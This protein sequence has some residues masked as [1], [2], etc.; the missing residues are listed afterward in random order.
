MK[1][2]DFGMG[3]PYPVRIHSVSSNV[4][5]QVASNHHLLSMQ[6]EHRDFVSAIFD[7]G[8]KAASPASVMA[9]MSPGAKMSFEGLNLERIKSKL[10]KFRN[11]KECHKEEF[12]AMY[13][14]T[15]SKFNHE[16]FP[17]GGREQKSK[18]ADRLRSLPPI[19]SLSSA[20]VAAFLSYTVMVNTEVNENSLYNFDGTGEL[21]IPELTEAEMK[22]PIGMAFK[23]FLRL[24]LCLE[25]DLK[26]SRSSSAGHQSGTKNDD[27]LLTQNSLSYSASI[28][29]SMKDTSSEPMHQN[30][31]NDSYGYS[32][33][34]LLPKN[35]SMDATM[36]SDPMHR[37][38]EINNYGY[39]HSSSLPNNSMGQQHIHDAYFGF[40]N[41]S[42]LP[43]YKGMEPIMPSAPLYHHP[44]MS[45]APIY[46][47]RGNSS[48]LTNNGGIEMNMPSTSMDKRR[49]SKIG[50]S[51]SLSSSEHDYEGYRNILRNNSNLDV[52]DS[53]YS[54]AHQQATSNLQMLS[55]VLSSRTEEEDRMNNQTHSGHLMQKGERKRKRKNDK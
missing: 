16:V 13:D 55:S 5:S 30:H 28:Q 32:H 47:H 38:H 42:S 23:S 24:F 48:S 19:E 3:Q 27:S 41:S 31:D 44:I 54:C 35:R 43:N 7:V 52:N 8:L 49:D 10:Q 6:K 12:L 53:N 33:S 15:I 25:K 36:S 45:S 39:S 26:L 17:V 46:H 22:L 1:K 2:H 21:E 11:K 50:F 20:E 14:K 18:L 34:L 4:V 9:Q 37:F 51:L 40:S 29:R